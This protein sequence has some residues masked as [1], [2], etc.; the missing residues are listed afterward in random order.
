MPVTTGVVAAVQPDSKKA[1]CLIFWTGR[2]GMLTVS[3]KTYCQNQHDA[4][5]GVLQLPA[6]SRFCELCEKNFEAACG[7]LKDRRTKG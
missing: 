7:Q 2:S 4:G 6:T 5:V 3:I 1:P